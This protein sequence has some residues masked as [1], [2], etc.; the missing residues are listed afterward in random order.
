[1]GKGQRAGDVNDADHVG[2]DDIVANAVPG[3]DQDTSA[4][5]GNLAA[6]PGCRGGPV[7]AL[8]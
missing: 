2:T 1:M 8:G 6:V 4:G 3:A 5:A 7:A